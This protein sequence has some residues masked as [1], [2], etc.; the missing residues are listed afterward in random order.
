MGNIYFIWG[1]FLF[2]QLVTLALMEG[3]V[4]NLRCKQVI[5]LGVIAHPGSYLRDVWNM[6]DALVVICAIISFIFDMTWVV[7]V[8]TS[9]A[10]LTTRRLQSVVACLPSYLLSQY[11]P[12]TSV[13]LCG[14]HWCVQWDTTKLHRSNL[15]FK[16]SFTR[17][18][19]DACRCGR[20]LR[21]GKVK[22]FLFLAALQQCAAATCGFPA[23][24][25]PSE[26]A[27]KCLTQRKSFHKKWL[28]KNK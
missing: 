16:G 1:Y 26:W 20:Q 13:A 22:L 6:M 2:P 12:W 14:I 7:V 10:S 15:K 28:G 9:H 25:W 27:F 23:N 3:S 19:F 18:A 5:D 17:R 8:V 21:C 11:K 4:F 24:L